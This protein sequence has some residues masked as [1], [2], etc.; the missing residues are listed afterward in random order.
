[1]TALATA[2]ARLGVLL[3]AALC[4]ALLVAGC[5]TSGSGSTD[6]GATPLQTDASTV[7]APTGGSDGSGDKIAASIAA[8]PVATVGRAEI[9][10]RL[11]LPRFT[12]VGETDSRGAKGSSG[13]LAFIDSESD[14][15]AFRPHLGS[16]LGRVAMAPDGRLIYVGDQ[17]EPV[18]WVVDAETHE[19]VGS[20]RLP[21]VTPSRRR[22]MTA[23]AKYPYT[24]LQTCSSAVACTP[25]GALVL[26]L[27]K[28]GLQVID[29]ASAKVVRTLPELRDGA[30]LAVSFDG[31][32][33]YIATTDAL[34]RG[35][36]TLADWRTI[37][38]SGAGGGLALLDLETW[39]IVKRVSCGVI[40]GIAVDPDD[41]R[42][43]CSDYKR[44]ALRIVDPVSL[45]DIAV[46][47]LKSDK[48][49]HFLPAGVGVLPDGSKAYVVCT[50]LVP[51]DPWTMANA[52]PMEFFC[53]VVATESQEVVKRIPLDAY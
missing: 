32:H 39:Q 34:T 22:T 25:D 19:K 53:A 6:N 8:T 18:V 41:S 5:G 43:F 28:A 26:V 27:S 2:A 30:E 46:V 24:Q 45:A 47:P 15:L 49:K 52:G 37:F 23:T 44:K 50:A 3:T 48:F 38:M 16:D 12:Y 10:R 21:G 11:A 51:S 4:A 42:I 7:A 35:R 31:R 36:H 29:A 33:A 1:M 20:I 40:G 9:E 13:A 17:D 14:T